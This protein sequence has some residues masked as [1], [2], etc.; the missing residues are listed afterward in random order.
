MSNR[1][2]SS[3]GKNGTPP[4]KS[5]GKSSGISL[6][7]SLGKKPRPKKASEARVYVKDDAPRRDSPRAPEKKMSQFN[8]RLG[9]FTIDRM[10]HDG[11]GIGD[12]K[13]KTLFVDGALTGERVSARLIEE[14]SRYSEARVDEVITAS[15]YRQAPSC[16]HFAQCGGCQLQHLNAEH[17]L[18]L[19]QDAVLEQLERWGGVI[20]KKIA[21]PITSASEG[22]RR[23]ARMGVWYEEKG[24]VTL[25]FRQRNTKQLVQVDTCVVLVPALN[26]LLAPLKNW[27]SELRSVKAVTHLELI[28]SDQG[29]AVVLRHTKKLDIADIAQL[30]VLTQKHEFAVW[31]QAGEAA[32]LKNLSGELVDPRL[33]YQLPEFN[34]ELG[35]H[36]QDFTQVNPAVNAQMIVQAIAWLELKGDERV[37]DLFCGIGN[38]TLPLARH[39]AQVFGMEA[40]EAMV[41]RGRE[42]AARAQITNATFLAA[43][44]VNTSENRLYQTCGNIDAILLDPP[45]DGAKEIIAVLLKLKGQQLKPKKIVYVSCNPATLAR[46]AKVLTEAGYV[47]HTLGVMDMFPHTAHVESMALFIRSK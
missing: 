26:K 18:I 30:S 2:G 40:E 13:S 23:T 10:S 27:L 9:E 36:P 12:W 45:R 39:C 31:L 33:V 22:Y 4:S 47:L 42:N 20:P 32:A 7:N 3:S 21:A 46:D 38:F 1:N 37:L 15:P 29:A 41:A 28:D 19:K 14:H 6:G 34:L 43:D 5:S 24:E 25:G 44:L 17:Q 16:V 35:F 11:R 8:M